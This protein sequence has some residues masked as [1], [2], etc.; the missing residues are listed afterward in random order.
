MARLGLAVGEIVEIHGKRLT[1]ARVMP[2]LME[3]RGQQTIEI[4]GIIRLNAQ[5]S[6]GDS[7]VVRRAESRPARTVTLATLEGEEKQSAIQNYG[8]LLEGLPLV[9]GD[10]VRLNLFG[11]SQRE[12]L[13]QQT[14]P[15]GTVIVS[16]ET[17]VKYSNRSQRG[18]QSRTTYEDVGG[19]GK[20]LTRIREIIELPL[21]YPEVFHRLGIDPP[22]GILMYGPPGTGKTL[23]ARAVAGETDAQFITVNGPEI[24]HKYYGES[25]ARLRE[26][27]EKAAA[28]P[29][30][31]I[32]LDE[33][34]AI[35]PKRDEVK[36]DVEKRVVAQLLSL[37]DGLQPRGRVV[38]VAATNLPNMLDPALRRPG[39]FDREIMINV[40][41]RSGRLE[42][43]QIHTRGMP[44]EDNVD[45]PHL[46][47]VTHGFVGADIQALCREAAMNALRDLMARCNDRPTDTDLSRITVAM[48]HYIRALNE[49]EPSA[50]REFAVE[51]PETRW[52]DIGGLE[53]IKRQLEENVV[54]PLRHQDLF[55]EMGVE[56][57]RGILFY[58]PPGTGKSLAGRALANEAG[59]NFLLVN[60]P[61]LLS[62]WVGE[63]ERELRKIFKQARQSAPCI[64]FFDEIDAMV[65]NR[66][67]GGSSVSERVLSQLLTELDGVEG[68][69]GVIPVGA[70]NRRDLIDQALLRSG[71]LELHLAFP[72]PN[73]DARKAILVIHAGK[74]RLSE[75]VDIAHL[76]R[77]TIGF[78]GAD[79]RYL[80][81]RAGL[82]AIREVV[83][84]GR[85]PGARSA[86]EVGWRHLADALQHMQKRSD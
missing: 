26:I 49:I 29:P 69:Q 59:A 31:I 80:C 46:A 47:E 21:R 54:W 7:V 13:V 64:I 56:P 62:K 52:S 85:E 51:I 1:V 42:I 73:E 22:K 79:L 37:M 23:I 71:R 44:L 70:T 86:P 67:G 63:S 35:A 58:G 5:A 83:R 2:A 6:L 40:P 65:G 61:A 30:S 66:S 16:K 55:D 36:G 78:S 48:P 12:F 76:A 11:S 41:D 33:V 60:G 39:R 53:E 18:E 15:D 81:H 19:L 8:G 4:D 20:Q 43:M 24:I 17:S 72:L 3:H 75:T 38:V 27:F 25:E 32:F 34:D 77:E 84:S 68:L 50:T 45:L 82:N 9:A 74:L 57:V 10:R 28:R 14:N